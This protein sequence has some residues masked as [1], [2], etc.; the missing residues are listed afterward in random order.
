[1]R[2]SDKL[3]IFHVAGIRQNSAAMFLT[4]VSPASPLGVYLVA[5]LPDVTGGRIR[6]NRKR[7]IMGLITAHR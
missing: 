6:I 4:R 1:M 3:Y 5:W 2:L 7:L